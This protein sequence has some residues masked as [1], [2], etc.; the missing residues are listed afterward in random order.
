M[1]NRPTSSEKGRAHVRA[2][3][4]SLCALLA[5]AQPAAAQRGGAPGARPKPAQSKARARVPAETLLQ[6]VQAEDERRWVDSD[7]ARLLI[8]SNAAVRARAAL[9]AGRIGDE[10]AVEPLAAL[11]RSER[12][13]T[14]RAV[15]AF[16]LG[17]VESEAGAAT[18][19]ETLRLS[20]SPELRAR[21]VEALGK[22]AAALPEA[23]ADAKK[24]IGEAITAALAAEQRLARPNRT[25]VLLGLTAMLRA[26]PENGART[27][28]LSLASTDARVRADAAN[29]LAR[30]RAK[31][32]LERLRVMLA[33]DADAVAR[34]NAAR[35]L[36]AAEDA[37]A[38][39]VLAQ[40]A[41]NDADERVRV[42]AV[43]ALAQIKER[44]AA[45][46][47]VRRGGELF[48]AYKTARVGGASN[49]AEVNEL[50]EVATSLGRVLANSNDARALTLLRAAR[51][52]GVVAPEVETALARIA[53]TQYLRDKGI[54]DFVAQASRRGAAGVTWQKVS[55][56]ALGLGEMAG[57]TSAQVGNSVVSL[58]ADAQIALRALVQSPS[59]PPS[60]LPDLLRSLAAFKP[61]DLAAVARA[62]LGNQD[63]IARATAAD[64]LAELPPDAETARALAGALPRA[65][66]DEINDAALSILGAL[67]RQQGPEAEQAVKSALE[68]TTDYLVRRRAADILRERAGGPAAERRVETVNT[69][70]RREDYERALARAGKSVRAVVL[71]DKGAFTL[72][73][74][75]EEAP[76]TVDNFV[77]LARRNYFNNV[78][79][80]RVVPN[81]VVQGGDPRGDG[82]GGPGYQIRCEI[83]DVPY[84]RGA[85]GMALSGKDT[86][87]SQWFVT[88]S[89][90][91]HL[92]GGYTVFGRVVEGMEVVD[93]IVRGDRIRSVTVTERGR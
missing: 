80:H 10:G 33:T 2:A 42:S 73:L 49:P 12:D 16:A 58:Q 64:I 44:R 91:P 45:D 1:P 83:N 90:Q 65:L 46:P 6:I 67:A 66:S 3:L 7:L 69:R 28:A 30:M 36:G 11:L 84:D 77:G 39:E 17:E 41:A 43:R 47:L 37:V 35:A 24:R 29:A 54:A 62:A 68:A 74:L 92:D 70:N 15:A 8:D 18:L 82:N 61:A 52:A 53:P 71:T 48:A 20:K 21:C 13:E 76:L 5:C 93:R 25:L 23:R 51:E 4:L 19:T 40:R 34:A 72:E 81:F 60:A 26:R 63:T 78:L 55:A 88:H 79:F 22:I 9:A 57:V 85:V 32:S 59:T 50:L 31:E 14:V 87:G 27:V 89:P 56:L 38:F 75:P 86:G